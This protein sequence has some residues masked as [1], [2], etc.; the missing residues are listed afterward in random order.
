MYSYYYSKK[1][2]NIFW[3][4]SNYFFETISSIIYWLYS[5]AE[6][7]PT[8]KEI[9]KKCCAA[10]FIW[11]LKKTLV[12]IGKKIAWKFWICF[13]WKRSVSNSF[14]FLWKNVLNSSWVI[15]SSSSESKI[16][17]LCIL[18]ALRL[19]DCDLSSADPYLTWPVTEPSRVEPSRA[20]P[21]LVTFSSPS[22]SLDIKLS[23]KSFL[24]HFWPT[25]SHHSIKRTVLLNDLIWNF[26]KNLY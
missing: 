8:R 7:Q 2:N 23:W 1:D 18:P 17:N 15:F 16:K 3:V 6:I 9:C 20:E 25:Y 26:S 21:S 19:S 24:G 14:T 12:V 13:L 11:H 22:H 10:L 4:P 5:C